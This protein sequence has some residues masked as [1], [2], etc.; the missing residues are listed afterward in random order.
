[1]GGV[2]TLT[3][4]YPVSANRYWRTVVNKKTLRAM[5]FVSEEAKSF[6]SEVGWTAKAQGL[7]T[8]LKGP[9]ELVVKLIPKNGVCMDLDNALKVTIDALKGIAYVDDSQVRR[10]DAERCEPDGQTSR[11]EV[12]INERTVEGLPLFSLSEQAQMQS[13]HVKQ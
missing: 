7:R 10:I 5:T 6:K 9:V 1:M 2:I 11:M 13:F 8:P 12:T 4:P 3:L